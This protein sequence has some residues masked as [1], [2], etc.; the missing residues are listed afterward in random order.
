MDNALIQ[1]QAGHG[2][3]EKAKITGNK[4]RIIKYLEQGLW[5]KDACIAAGVSEA[6]GHRY[7][8]IDES[9]KSQCEAAIS[10][11]KEKLIRCI[12]EHALRDGRL[13]LEV[14]RIRFPE[15]WNPKRQIQMFNPQE[16]LRKV[17]DMIYKGNCP[18]EVHE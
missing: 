12:N 16:E 13:A 11:Y 17:H 6:T 15:E 8:S 5:F 4:F 10:K 18:R 2:Q 3:E 9:F 7:K 14:L 1:I